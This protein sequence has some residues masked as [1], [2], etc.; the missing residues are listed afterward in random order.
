[1][2]ALGSCVPQRFDNPE[3]Y[4]MLVL[5][6]LYCFTIARLLVP[7]TSALSIFNFRV[8]GL[9]FGACIVDF[10]LPIDPALLLV[11]GH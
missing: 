5:V 7:V 2:S 8:E 4:V 6:T 3:A 9:E 1:M 10:E 11:A